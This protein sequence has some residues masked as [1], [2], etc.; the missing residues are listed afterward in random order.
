MAFI[1][2][3]NMYLSII[4]KMID[5][6]KREEEIYIK[7]NPQYFDTVICYRNKKF[8]LNYEFDISYYATV[9]KG[10]MV[11]DLISQLIEKIKDI[12]EV[13][14][15]IEKDYKEFY[16]YLQDDEFKAKAVRFKT[17]D[18]IRE[19]LKTEVSKCSINDLTRLVKDYTLYKIKNGLEDNE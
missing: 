3:E 2:N 16:S 13:I 17:E 7:Q 1:K 10:E 8:N 5:I 15:Y 11:P 12:R 14:S 19:E 4:E 6:D 9:N 18:I